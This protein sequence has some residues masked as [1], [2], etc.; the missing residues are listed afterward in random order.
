L[1]AMH[2]PSMHWPWHHPPPP[3]AP[4]VHELDISAGAGAGAAVG[5]GG[6]GAASAYPQYWNR[7]TLVVDLAA[8][9]G[10]GSITLKPAAGSAWPVRLA[11]RVTPGSVGLLSVRA[12]QRLVIP[13]TPAAGKPIE[14][15]LAPRMYT[16]TTPQMLVSWGRT[17]LRCPEAAPTREPRRPRGMPARAAMRRISQRQSADSP[18]TARKSPRARSR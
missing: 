12:D 9:S 1:P 3:P 2:W 13:S 8:A 18:C 7:N 15:E 4:P 6:S 10:S 11:F 16:S 5:S 14:L 17:V